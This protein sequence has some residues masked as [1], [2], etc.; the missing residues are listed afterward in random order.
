MTR[1]E[2][3]AAVIGAA[4]RFPSADSVEAYWQLL[5][6]GRAVAAEPDATR[7][8]LWSAA[9]DPEL[10]ARLTTLK[11]G[12][13]RDILGFDA[14]YFGIAPREAAKLDPQQ[15]LLLAAT[16]DALDDAGLTRERLR[17]LTV[18]VFV[19]A[20]SNDYMMLG[21]R[22]RYAIDGYHGLGNSHSILANR[23]SYYYN[24]KGPSLTVDT[25]CSSSL[26]ALH[27]AL[28][29]L[30]QGELDLAIVGGVNVIVSPDLTLAFSQA[31]MLSP[32]GRC[33]TF[34]AH[35]DGYGRAEGVG[36]VVL[37]RAAGR[38]ALDDVRARC[39]ILSSAVNQD[40]RSN[41]ITAPNGASQVEVIGA[42]MARAGIDPADVAY[43]ETHGTGTKLGDAIEFN[44]LRE[45]FAG[46][47]DAHCHVGSAKASVGHMEAAAGM[48]GLIKAMLM[49]EHGTIA[50]HAVK[51]P[52]N[53]LLKQAGGQLDIAQA[54]LPLPERSCIG[55]SSF[56]FGG[57]N[58]HV[59][60]ARANGQGNDTAQVGLADAAVDEG[61]A[62]LL[63]STHHASLLADDAARLATFLAN[64][65]PPLQAVAS[66]LAHHRDTLRHRVALVASNRAD[67]IRTLEKIEPPGRSQSGATPRAPRIAF[68]FTGQ[69]SQYAGM[70]AHLYA[71]NTTFRDAFDD[72]AARIRGCSGFGVE[73]LLHGG[74]AGEQRLLDDTHLAQLALF[75][76][77]YALAQLA[78]AAGVVPSAA[79]GHSI[80]EIVAQTLAGMLGLDS[81]VALVHERARFMQAH[82][83][84]GA[85]LG[86][87]ASEAGVA[88]AITRSQLPVHIAAVNGATSVTV[89]GPSAAIDAFEAQLTTQGMPMRRLRT[90]HAFHTPA[91]APAAAQL[92]RFTR[93]LA[94]RP[95]S[96]PVV[97][98][99]DGALLDALPAGSDYW[100]RQIVAPVMFAH[101]V[102]TLIEQGINVFLEIGPDRVLSQVIT[103][104]HG[105]AG[106]EALSLQR[107]GGD[108]VAEFMTALG[109]LFER[110]IDIDAG[111]LVPR[112]PPVRLPARSLREQPYWGLPAPDDEHGT[113]HT[114]VPARS[115]S[116]VEA[117]GASAA[118][119]STKHTLIDLQLDVMRRQLALLDARKRAAS[120]RR[121]LAPSKE[122]H[123]G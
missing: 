53:E 40:G 19:G 95:A 88:D 108:N 76:L 107:R 49:L 10:A 97:S 119:P 28:Q 17:T 90:R 69:G 123:H 116:T 38:H 74:N 16:H 101:G 83:P 9:R 93:G 41:G 106:I 31:S 87:F 86:V 52:Y 82:R 109:R 120:S 121:P 71:A 29:S 58:A 12:Y 25:A 73:D 26:T 39:M 111:A 43:V 2:P 18:G 79:I 81:A 66:T 5:L 78:I 50:P 65:P 92:A 27:V 77:E 85:M 6:E 104:D 118:L 96:L 56:G 48:G 54:P 72:C 122:P 47:P 94:T 84:A 61:P 13:L 89:S 8:D 4:C 15:R 105:D 110:Q 33:N 68:V 75:G 21:G 103:R 37:T 3:I 64:S 22:S 7:L 112:L 80:G 45:V 100:S 24:F 30:A 117:C 59:I 70:G 11:G 113:P 32:S 46:S 23:I 60:V 115:T 51:P 55:I 42:A 102:E 1:A 34:S 57:S 20:G 98:N 35:A 99:L 36:V 63:M 14:D 114:S 44:A 67:A 91:L 62:L